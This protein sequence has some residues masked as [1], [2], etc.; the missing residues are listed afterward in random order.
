MLI[1]QESG[2]EVH[3][4]CDRWRAGPIGPPPRPPRRPRGRRDLLRR[5][6]C[7]ERDGDP[8]RPEAVGG[9]P[10][11]DQLRIRRDEPGGL[12]VLADGRYAVTGPL[13]AVGRAARCRS[14]RG[15]GCAASPDERAWLRR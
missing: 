4:I 1:R 5:A 10:V 7:R 3:D 14:G 15:G 6:P 11:I 13:A 2:R 9:R 8:A 12:W